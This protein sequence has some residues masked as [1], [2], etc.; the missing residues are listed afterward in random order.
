M[1]PILD[2]RRFSG[3]A[4]MEGVVRQTSVDY[5]ALLV[6]AGTSPQ[7][8]VVGAL[9]LNA[10]ADRYEG[11]HGSA[12]LVQMVPDGIT[13]LFDLAQ[14]VGLDRADR[15]V[16][17]WALTP[18]T[19]A[20]RD[21]TYQRRFPM[22]APDAGAPA[23][24]RGHRILHVSGGQHGPNIYRQ[25]AALNRGWSAE[26]KRYRALERE[27]AATPGTFFFGHLIYV[28]DTDYP[29]EV[30]IGLLRPGRL[31]VERFSNRPASV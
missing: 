24:D 23:V 28:D 8:M 1:V 19:V 13:Y 9:L 31:H 11:E 7:P 4:N 3:C 21:T 16:A 10:L 15:T 2:F 25:D 26:G 12:G 27:A 14:S 6:T 22:Y 29:V 20:R 30:E 18:P 17:A 5:D